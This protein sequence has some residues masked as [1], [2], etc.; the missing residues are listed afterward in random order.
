[1]ILYRYRHF[2]QLYARGELFDMTETNRYTPFDMIRIGETDIRNRK[3]AVKKTFISGCFMVY[4][5]SGIYLPSFSE[6]K[7]R[8]AFATVCLSSSVMP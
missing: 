5:S 1:M 4:F 2:S 7:D 6:K 3:N 8:T